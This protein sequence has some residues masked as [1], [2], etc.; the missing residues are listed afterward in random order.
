MLEINVQKQLGQLDLQ[1]NLNIPNPNITAVF[2]VSGS[3][4]S[5][6]IN[7]ISGLSQ[8]D[9]GYIRLNQQ[10]LVD[11]QQGICLP[12]HQRRMGYVFQDGRL[13]PHYSV[14]G[15]L[16]YGINKSQPRAETAVQ[17]ERIIELLGLEKLLRRYPISLSGG[18]K[19]RVAIGRALLTQPQMLLMD[20]PLSALDLPR[21]Q[22]LLAYL[23][24]LVN[25]I[26]IPILYVT[27]SLDELQALAEQVILLEQGK[28]LAYDQLHKVMQSPLFDKWL[29]LDK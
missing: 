25:E 17:F 21:K 28:V 20:E 8:P 23:A 2:G 27:H 7:L 16:C 6:L 5:S 3:G 4:K 29:L 13:F 14:K 24:K 12:P 19:Q 26:S 11:C 22:E 1:V 15:N 18:E 9:Q 10:T